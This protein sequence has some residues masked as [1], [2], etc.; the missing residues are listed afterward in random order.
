MSGRL[1]PAFA[2]GAA[3]CAAAMPAFAITCFQ[4]IDRSDVVI[5]RGTSSPVD[6]SNAGVLARE[7]MRG[8]GE[9]L[10]IFDVETCWEVS[11]ASPVGSRSRATDEIVAGWRSF[12]N[13]GFGGTYG[14]TVATDSGGGISAPMPT[15]VGRTP[16]ARGA[17]AARAAGY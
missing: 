11:R 6:L 4:V 8:R 13:S 12:G 2:I 17:V 9:H 3:L 7:A 14:S 10:V 1:F 15:D 16:A 5:F